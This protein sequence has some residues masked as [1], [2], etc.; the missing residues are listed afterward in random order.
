M[1]RFYQTL[2][3]CREALYTSITLNIEQYKGVISKETMIM[4]TNAINNQKAK[5]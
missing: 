5:F 4:K 3:I 2:R 1:L